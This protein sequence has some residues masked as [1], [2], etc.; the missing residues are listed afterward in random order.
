MVYRATYF[1]A[2]QLLTILNFLGNADRCMAAVSEIGILVF[3]ANFTEMF[4]NISPLRV[5]YIPCSHALFYYLVLNL[6]QLNI[7]NPIFKL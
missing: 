2:K 4:R 6:T 1:V 7:K 3:N 5:K